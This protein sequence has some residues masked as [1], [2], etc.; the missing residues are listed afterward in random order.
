MKICV[1]WFYRQSLCNYWV[2]KVTP[3]FTDQIGLAL[4]IIALL[5]YIDG[6]ISIQNAF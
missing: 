4:A 3:G 5:E 1:S 6:T 2:T